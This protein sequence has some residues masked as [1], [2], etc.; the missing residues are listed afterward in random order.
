MPPE[1][2]IN[3]FSSV[4]RTTKGLTI[5]IYTTVIT[6][7]IIP[8]QNVLN[9]IATCRKAY[10]GI[11]ILVISSVVDAN[12]IKSWLAAGNNGYLSKVVN[13]VKLNMRLIVTQRKHPMNHIFLVRNVVF[14]FDLKTNQNGSVGRDVQISKRMA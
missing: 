4:E 8:G 6:D 12:S 11:I 2:T 7:L 5:E 1:S 3:I 14:T 13:P 9:F 10:K